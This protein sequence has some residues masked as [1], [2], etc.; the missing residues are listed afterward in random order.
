MNNWRLRSSLA[1]SMASILMVTWSAE[2]QVRNSGRSCEVMRWRACSF[3]RASSLTVSLQ[4]DSLR[5]SS[6]WINYEGRREERE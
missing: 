1:T 2:R 6:L 5:F 4:S 3:L